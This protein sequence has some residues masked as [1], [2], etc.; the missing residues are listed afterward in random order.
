MDEKK[1]SGS[2]STPLECPSDTI[3]HQLEGKEGRNGVGNQEKQ[4]WKA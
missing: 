3:L 1:I 2:K 4:K